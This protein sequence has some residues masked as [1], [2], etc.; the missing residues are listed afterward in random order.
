MPKSLQKFLA[1]LDDTEVH[2]LFQWFKDSSFPYNFIVESMKETIEDSHRH[3]FKE[4]YYTDNL[5]DKMEAFD[6][7]REKDFSD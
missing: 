2:E 1:G 7:K 4:L 6:S 5:F 3:L